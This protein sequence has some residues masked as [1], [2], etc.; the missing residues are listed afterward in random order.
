MENTIKPQI[1]AEENPS[2]GSSRSAAA[3]TMS[4]RLRLETIA[5][6]DGGSSFSRMLG[7]GS[8]A[9]EVWLLVVGFGCW[10]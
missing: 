1:F 6:S 3:A 2:S 7:K 10:L 8:G 9:F 4:G 5:S